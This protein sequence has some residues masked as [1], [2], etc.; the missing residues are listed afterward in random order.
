VLSHSDATAKGKPPGKLW[1]QIGET[2]T[3]LDK[4]VRKRIAFA[5]PF[6]TENDPFVFLPRQPR[7]KHREST[8]KHE[9]VFLQVSFFGEDPKKFKAQ[10]V[11]KIISS[12]CDDYTK[13]CAMTPYLLCSALLALLCAALRCAAVLSAHAAVQA[14]CRLMLA[15]A[16]PSCSCGW[17]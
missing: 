7:D 9:F 11:L 3:G 8:Q 14:A 17:R 4:L 16:T 10:D 1:A 12:T 5:L 2:K 15:T 6:Y 13:A